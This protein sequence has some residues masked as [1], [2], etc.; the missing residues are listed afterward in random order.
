[1]FHDPG[2]KGCLD[3]TDQISSTLSGV[4]AD[5]SK[6]SERTVFWDDDLGVNVDP[7]KGVD[8]GF[9]AAD[10]DT[11]V[12]VLSY[13]ALVLLTVAFYCSSSRFC[14]NWSSCS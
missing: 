1:M 5:Y 9:F 10:W 3:S 11:K 14:A 2:N 13:T 6:S 8:G 12:C 7:F 4:L